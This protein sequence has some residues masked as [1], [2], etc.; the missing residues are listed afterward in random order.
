M[1]DFEQ[2]HPISPP[3]GEVADA[4]ADSSADC[5]TAQEERGL[6]GWSGVERAAVDRYIESRVAEELG[7]QMA[8]LGRSGGPGASAPADTMASRV[9]VKELVKLMPPGLRSPS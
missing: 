3:Q 6:T 7:R 9:G 2:S 1:A 5:P 8:R 4:V